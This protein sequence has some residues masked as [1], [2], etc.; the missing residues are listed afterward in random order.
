MPAPAS[1]PPLWLAAAAAASFWV[2]VFGFTRLIRLFLDDP[3][4]NDFKI[5]YAAAKVGLGAGWSRIYDADLQRTASAAFAVKDRVIDHEHIYAF[6]PLLAWIVAPLTALSEPAAFV[7]WTVI[8]LAALVLAW[9]VSSPF[10]GLAR[11]TLLLLG[12]ALWSVNESL[13]LGQ[14]TLLLMAVIA[15]AWQQAG[16]NR[17][18]VAG[19]LVG[20]AVMLKPQDVFLVP[21][22]LLVSGRLQV[23]VGFLAC[24][25]ALAIAFVLSLGS[26]G[27]NGYIG[28]TALVQSDSVVQFDT[29]AYVFGIGPVAYAAE[30]VVGAIAMIIAYLRRAEL[31]IVFALGL[32]GSAIASPHM[33]QPDYA[34][35]LLA[36][37]LV[38][39]TGLGLAHGLW[40][41]GGI[42]AAQFT[43]LAVGN[44]L[45]QLVW[46]VGWLGILGRNAMVRKRPAPAPAEHAPEG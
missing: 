44:P 18:L 7:L 43:S 19:A 17:P 4:A 9:A 34:L 1:R 41:V 23:F 3:Y 31:D 35:N 28:V 15:V 25:A 13:N 46:Q 14:P 45:P 29:L 24:A 12:L 32:I 37:W 39:R 30:F 11:I 22:A 42:P 2:A 40:L 8:G 6:P 20:F 21:I 38:L 33:H 10:S 16:R 5:F 27:I 36:A 26:V